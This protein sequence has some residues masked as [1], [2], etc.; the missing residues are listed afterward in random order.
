MLNKKLKIFIA[1]LISVVFIDQLSK[2]IV[3]KYFYNQTINIIKPFL[4]IS[5][6]KHTHDTFNLIDDYHIIIGKLAGAIIV[7]FLFV[8][9]LFYIKLNSNL[10]IL[11]LSLLIA[12]GI[13]NSIDLSVQGYVI[14]FINIHIHHFWIAF[15]I[16][17]FT[18][19][20]GFL[21]LL[22]SLIIAVFYTIRGK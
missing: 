1:T 4:F 2:F 19:I 11:S 20:M 13:S 18:V 6:I 12:G 16:A 15:N 21:L 5:F 3:S 17:D 7:T 10:F 22:I 8:F 14:D 9:V